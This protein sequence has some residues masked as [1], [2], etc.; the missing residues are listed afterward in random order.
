MQPGPGWGHADLNESQGLSYCLSKG[1]EPDLTRT[2]LPIVTSL[3][4]ADSLCLVVRD[5]LSLLARNHL[6]FRQV[7][8]SEP[9][10]GACIECTW[11]KYH[12]CTTTYV[13]WSMD[14]NGRVYCVFTL[15]LNPKKSVQTAYI[16]I[17]HS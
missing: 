2:L 16:H 3:F 12:V 5:R 1:F 6:N 7:P 17:C 14:C 10:L 15:K 11:H 13:P 8:E 9:D 4:R